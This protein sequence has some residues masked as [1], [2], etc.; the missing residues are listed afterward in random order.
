VDIDPAPELPDD[1][2]INRVRLPTRIRTALNDAGVKTIGEIREATDDTLLGFQNLGHVS[3]SYLRRMFG[4]P[5]S[6]GV[7]PP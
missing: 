6:G 5:S 7:R 1:T 3:L 2:P 4:L